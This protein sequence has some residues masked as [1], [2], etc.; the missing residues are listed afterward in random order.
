[1]TSL[2]TPLDINYEAILDA[3]A[4]I[5]T[6]SAWSGKDMG[7]NDLWVAAIAQVYDLTVLTTDKDFDHLHQAGLI[8]VEWVDPT[9]S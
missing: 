1:M 8:D 3:Y 5:D 4:S 9:S 7:K 2:F 6:R